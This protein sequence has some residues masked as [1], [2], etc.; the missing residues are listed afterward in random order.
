LKSFDAKAVA[1]FIRKGKVV[2]EVTLSDNTL[3]LAL[4]KSGGRIILF[5][6]N[7]HADERPCTVMHEGKF[8]LKPLWTSGKF[9]GAVEERDVKLAPHE[10]GVWS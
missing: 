10:I 6:R 5:V 8:V 2:P 4:H 9:L 3:D 7:P 1:N